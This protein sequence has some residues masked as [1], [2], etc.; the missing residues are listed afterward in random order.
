MICLFYAWIE[1]WVT[2]VIEFVQTESI[3][4]LRH[5]H[6]TF[7]KFFLFLFSEKIKANTETLVKG[8]QIVEGKCMQVCRVLR[9]RGDCAIL[10]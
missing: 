6:L 3:V 10:T 9:K 2:H 1:V 8:V 7:C 5:A 4:H